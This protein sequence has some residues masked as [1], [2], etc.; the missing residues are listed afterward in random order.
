MAEDSGELKTAFEWNEHPRN[1]VRIMGWTEFN[2]QGRPVIGR[3]DLI[4]WDEFRARR[5][6][7]AVSVTILVPFTELGPDD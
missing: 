2:P 4:T 7:T 6:S 5:N 1:K 3:D